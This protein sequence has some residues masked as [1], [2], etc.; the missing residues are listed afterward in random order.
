MF[1]I[2]KTRKLSYLIHSNSERDFNYKLS[3]FFKTLDAIGILTKTTAIR[4]R[5]LPRTTVFA[6]PLIELLL[7]FKPGQL[8]SIEFFNPNQFAMLT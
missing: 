6:N 2:L 1:Q 5:P 4:L 7:K 8:K 3:L